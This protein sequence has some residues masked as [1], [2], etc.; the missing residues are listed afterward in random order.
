[1]S[2]SQDQNKSITDQLL[3]RENALLLRQS[4][5]W[6]Q[7][8][9]ILMLGL[10]VGMIGAGYL[11]KIDEV[12][13]A[14]GQLKS[15]GGRKDVTTPASGKIAKVYVKNGQHVKRNDLL[16][17]FDTT[18][19]AESKSRSENL[20]HLESIGLEKKLRSLEYQT[21]T[22]QQRL[23]TQETIAKE[24]QKLSTIGG[25]AELSYLEVQDKV[26]ELKNQLSQLQERS[27]EIEIES[28]KRIRGLKS[29][30]E[31]AKQQLKYQTV[32][33]SSSGIVFD[34]QAIEDGVIASGST[35]LSIIP[36]DGLKAEVYIP[37][38]DI[39]F[40]KI[41]QKAQVRVD[42]F[43]SNRYGE[44]NG[45]VRLVGADALPPNNTISFYHFPIDISL[46]QSYLESNEMQIPLRSGMAITSNLI[47]RDKKII[48]II[49]DFFSGQVNSIKAL[50]N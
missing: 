46:E 13:T 16:I 11:V 36:I 35:I 14:T 30:L 25:I 45:S 21:N 40:V 33:A 34:I 15:I 7:F 31:N 24:Y 20:I 38:K 47:I 3:D 23:K 22:I 37:N 26:Y 50:R 43:P 39:G 18:L 27:K 29:E 32:S 9:A 19:A 5:K 28:Q 6:L 1:M 48:S 17:E 8:F 4:P 10:G 42:A 49:G 41:G 2:Q 44:I 12:V